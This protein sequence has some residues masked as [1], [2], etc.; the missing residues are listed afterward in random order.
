MAM[1]QLAYSVFLLGAALHRGKAQ[2]PIGGYSGSHRNLS[3]WCGKPY[4]A[5]SVVSP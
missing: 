3:R 2:D 1:K 4:M 5:G